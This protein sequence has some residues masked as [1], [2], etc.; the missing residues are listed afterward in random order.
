[1]C[2]VCSKPNPKH[3][4]DIKNTA[5]C[6]ENWQ[7]ILRRNLAVTETSRRVTKKSPDQRLPWRDAGDRDLLWDPPLRR[8]PGLAPARLAT[9]GPDPEHDRE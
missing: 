2:E 6:Q 3:R 5:G 7:D 8:R 4:V 9:V 1:M